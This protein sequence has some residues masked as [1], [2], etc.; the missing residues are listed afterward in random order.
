M[1]MHWLHTDSTQVTNLQNHIIHSLGCRHQSPVARPHLKT[2]HRPWIAE[3][4]AAAVA[5]AVAAAVVTTRK[6]IGT[7][8]FMH[9]ICDFM[10]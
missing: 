4:A 8:M 7:I 3:F 6:A 5:E 10:V 2:I 1:I 9:C